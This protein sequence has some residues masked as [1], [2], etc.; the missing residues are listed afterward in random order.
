MR[1]VVVLLAYLGALAFGTD[2]AFAPTL[3]SGFDRVQAD[4]G[5][6]VLNHYI[7]EHSWQA[8]TDPDYC[9]SLFSPP[10]FYPTRSTL[11]YS[12]HLLGVAPLYWALRAVM[13]H[14]GAY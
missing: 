11:W 14:V 8:L 1:K 4:R 12:E 10:C 7:L 5:D 6:S 2:R 3:H 13:D 9:G